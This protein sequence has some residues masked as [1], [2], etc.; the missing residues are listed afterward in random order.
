MLLTVF[1]LTAQLGTGAGAWRPDGPAEAR[2]SI[3]LARLLER[4]RTLHPHLSAA[5]ARVDAAR[6]ARRAAGAFPNPVLQFGIANAALPG[7]GPLV[8]IDHEATSTATVPLEFLYQRG[9]RVHRADAELEAAQ[10]DA[11]A[12][13]QRVA[14]EAA[15]SYY[16]VAL[17]EVE[18]A[19]ALDLSNWLDSL[20]S[21]SRL[22]VVEGAAAGADLLR[23]ELEHDRAGAEV[24]LRQTALAQARAGLG[25]FYGDSIGPPGSIPPIVIPAAPL[26]RPLLGAP[27][28]PRPEVRSARARLVAAQAGVG[29]ARSMIVRDLSAMVG[30]KRSV[31]TTSLLAGIVLPLPIVNANRGALD[32]AEAERAAATFDLAVVDRQVRSETAGVVE[33]ARLLR[34][35]IQVLAGSRD[36]SGTRTGYLARADEARRIAVG[37]YREG[38]VPLFQVLDAARAWGEARLIYF[39]TL[40]A[41]HESVVALLAAEGHDLFTAFDGEELRQ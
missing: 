7:R 12:G 16:R 32:Q 38:A 31:G 24:T 13:R 37:A 15:Q 17:A 23:A 21:Y 26:A 33:G 34:E 41:Q 39:R 10:A 6:G 3:S 30:L 8:G 27:V 35:R 9:A 14:V 25:F 40:F 19:T 36:S 5:A 2:D 1:V 11:F 22:R 20:V 18:L 28:G 4:V 29:I